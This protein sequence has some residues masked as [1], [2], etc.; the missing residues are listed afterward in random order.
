[1]FSVTTRIKNVRQPR[2]G[3]IPP[4]ELKETKYFDEHKIKKINSAYKPI[5]GMAV[6]YLTRFMNGTPKHTAFQISLMGAKRVDELDNAYKLLNNIKGL[7]TVSIHNACQLVGYD[8]AYRRGELY[9]TPV[10]RIVPDKYMV[11]NIVILVNRCLTFL[12]N[13]GPII[14]DGFTFEGGYNDVVS[15]GDGDYLTQNTL[16]DFKVSEAEPTIYHTLQLMVYYILGI[17]SI[18]P[19]FQR[20][21]K[22]GIYNPELNASYTISLSS[23]SDDTFYNVSRDVIGYCMPNR[24]EQWRYATGTSEKAV[25]E[26]KSY[27]IDI[28]K[29]TGF[30]TD[31]YEDGIHDITVDDYWSF[32]QKITTNRRPKFT[33]THSV[34]F[35]KNSGFFMFV[36]VSEKG[37]TSIMQGGS[38]RKLKRPLEYYYQRFP[39]YANTVLLKF[40]K[41][42]DALYSISKQ[43]QSIAPNEE[44]IKNCYKRYVDG[45]KER[46]AFWLD[47]ELWKL[48]YKNQYSF[49]GKVHGCIVDIDYFNHIYLNPYNGSIAPYSAP[50]M[51][52]KYVYTN[53]PSLIATQRPEMLPAFNRAIEA[54]TDKESTALVLADSKVTRALSVLEQQ[55]IDTYNVPVTDASMYRL[56]NRMKQLQTIYDYH[57]VGVWYDNILPHYELEGER[58]LPKSLAI[59][60]ISNPSLKQARGESATLKTYIG[61]TAVM[62]CGLRA[63]V[64]EDFGCN[65]ITVQFEDGLIKKHCRRDKFREGKIGHKE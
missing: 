40:S 60:K 59:G 30:S 9:Y 25:N 19:E 24:I 14:S 61:K 65:N 57:Y 63:T 51:Y 26:L 38:L 54:S 11:Q 20:L 15:S 56:S 50:S 16:W 13:I 62:N 49:S 34:K 28:F 48:L 36:S 22:L 52:M 4:K 64:I 33:H 10:D 41:Y 45:C 46:D 6:D 35:I 32:Y 23:I 53:V 21:K 18:H 17:H 42:W 58:K 31:K 27:C 3:Y 1:M 29:D 44:E 37:T 55:E 8:F 7:D 2:L 5:Q 43:V 47:Y 12:K 39:E